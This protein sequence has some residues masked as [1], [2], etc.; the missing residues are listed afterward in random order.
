MPKPG[1]APSATAEED[2]TS[3]PEDNTWPDDKIWPEESTTPEEAWTEDEDL[4]ALVPESPQLARIEMMAN[5]AITLRFM[6]T[7]TN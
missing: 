6:R 4:V 3:A 1:M 2:E 7:S 5:P